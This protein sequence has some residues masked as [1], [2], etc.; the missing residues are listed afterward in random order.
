MSSGP[1]RRDWLAAML[2]VR[3]AASGTSACAWRS[4]TRRC[5]SSDRIAI[6]LLTY[7]L[8]AVSLTQRDRQILQGKLGDYAAAY[9]RGGIN[10]LA[11]TVRA[12]QR[13]APERL[14][15][16]VDRP[17]RRGRRAQQP[18]RLGSGH[19]R[20]GVG[21]AGGRHAGAGGEEHR[22]ARGAAGAV[23]RRARHGDAVDRRD[24]AHRRLARDPV[25]AVSDPPADAS[26]P[27]HHPHRP[28]R[29]ARAACRA[30]ATRSTS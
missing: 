25:G 8:T 26:R 1:R 20:D 30:P 5:S 17:R 15:V 4:G 2:G 19:A 23:S 6:V 11:D 10:V 27:A 22:G 3:L 28:H 12:E 13:A 29:R 24:R 14:F 9:L 21:P 18:R 16:R 7:Y